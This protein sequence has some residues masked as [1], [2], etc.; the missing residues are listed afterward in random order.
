VENKLREEQYGFRDNRSM[1]DLIFA[2]RRISEKRWE[3]VKDTCLA[4]IDSEKSYNSINRYILH[5]N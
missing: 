1:I 3:F 2:V 4:F 5:R